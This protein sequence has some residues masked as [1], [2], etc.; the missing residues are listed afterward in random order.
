MK[1]ETQ[2]VVVY[3]GM[4]LVL[5]VWLR[6]GSAGTTFVATLFNGIKGLVSSATG[7]GSLLIIA[8]GSG[9]GSGNIGMN[10]QLDTNV[11]GMARSF[12]N[13]GGSHKAFTCNPLVP[14]NVA[15]GSHTITL[16]A[17]A[18]TSSDGNDWFNVT[19]LEFPF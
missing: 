4:A 2:D 5:V 15:A 1:K 17:L 19:V 7:G 14:R 16:T 10:I 6:P 11:I 13:E 3:F 8:S 12:T 18:G 9:W